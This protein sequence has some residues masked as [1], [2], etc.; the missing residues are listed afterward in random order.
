MASRGPR[1][2]TYLL[3]ALALGCT[4]RGDGSAAPGDQLGE[5]MAAPLTALLPAPPTSD[6]KD[7]DEPKWDVNN[8]Q[9]LDLE[10]IKLD[11]R[12]GTWLSLDISPDGKEI[13]F[14][15]LGDLYT[16]PIEG[17]EAT[18]LTEG[19]AWDMQPTYSPD[20]RSIA[21]TSDRGGGD[22]LWVVPRGGGEA[23]P[24]TKESFRLLNSP[25]WSPDGQYLVGRKHYTGT[26][27]L[28]AG[29]LW[30][31]HHS[32]G[33]GVQLTERANDQKDLGEP[34]FSPDGR[35]VYYSYDAT[36][37]R[38]FEYN[39]DPHAGIYEIERVDLVEQR[40]EHVVGGAGGA[41]RP[42]PSPDGRWLAYV[43]RVGL[44]T[45]LFV[46]D[47]ESGAQRQLFD[48]LDRDMQETWAIHGVYPR[49]DWTPDGGAIV[50]W[51]QG[52]LH[53]VDIA[54]G[55]VTAVPFHVAHSRKIGKA[56]RN[57]VE[58]HPENFD[59]KMLRGLTVAPDGQRVVYQA[60]GHLYVRE[61]PDG[62]ARRLTRDDDVFEHDPSISRDGRTV[63]Y[64]TW[65]DQGLGELRT[66]PLKGGRAKTISR[67]KGHYRE[68]VL[69]PDGDHV[70]FRRLG[71]GYL[72]SRLW[73][74]D[75]GIY[76][77]PLRKPKGDDKPL[78][79]SRSGSGIHFG[80]DGERVFFTTRS[81]GKDATTTL[82]SIGLDGREER[83]HATS[84]N[85]A[86]FRVSPD[87]KWLAFQ[88]RFHAYV[89]AFPPSN[90]PIRVGP[91][92][93]GIP[94][95]KVTQDAGT[96]LRWAGDSG[97]VHWLLG[98]ELFTR[99]LEDSFAFLRG[100]APETAEGDED[101]AET[102]KPVPSSGV[103]VGF[104][105]ASDIPEGRIALVG[106]KVVT[107]VGDQV[108]DDGV[109][110]IEGNRIVAVGE[111]GSV[112][113]PADA[114]S[115]D[116]SGHTVIPGL[117]DVHAHGPQGT[118]GIIPQQ[119]WLHYS[120]LAFGVT[121]VHDPS[122]DT[123]TIFASA[124]LA[125]AGLVTAPRIFSTG[126]ILYGAETPFM[127]VVN[128]LDD[129]RTHLRRMKA[130]GAISVKSY[131]QPRR[132]QRQQVLAAAKEIDM[133]VVPEGG[134][135]FQHNM[136][137]VVDGHTGVE[138]AIPVGAAYDDVEQLWG[139]TGVGYTPTLV[140]GYGGIWGEN[141]WYAES[142]VFNN[143]R[144][145]A[146][147][148]PFVYEGRSRRRMLASKGDWNHFAIAETCKQLL[149]AGVHIQLGAHGQREGLAAHWELW[150]LGQGGMTALEAI[151]AATLHG[152]AYVGLDRDLGSLEAGKLADI[153][154]VEGDLLADLR[155]SEHVKYTVLNGRVFEAKTMEQLAPVEIAPAPF[156]WHKGG[157]DGSAA[158][159]EAH[160]FHED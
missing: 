75:P 1:R 30:L 57:P 86:E 50:L 62:Q 66:V 88:E 40:I 42:T 21:F 139:Q 108:I 100:D 69:S 102:A 49:M 4:P 112:E 41:V 99:P 107:M 144:L 114:K 132:D 29:E 116:V 98:P 18:P 20:G 19:M 79:L 16:L 53:R 32:G 123:A 5:P 110:V 158:G 82:R 113:I 156:F 56:V 80:A 77:A 115:F 71:G 63:V 14:D 28:G 9:G 154:V 25:A 65:N 54:S 74:R 59:V 67:W 89:A 146:F 92:A 13:V 149:D 120:T 95:A 93:D 55:E 39:K 35:Y 37:G 134:S 121:T 119:N 124:E 127:A 137:F 142:D 152:A 122:N 133:M 61:L 90:R 135:L 143:R 81:G 52:G 160:T 131:N 159:G 111:R 48:G 118:G 7:E 36:P 38:Y 17:G 128:S 3:V 155:R 24:V 136:T 8:P 64:A 68:P 140:V 109:V 26:R 130:V 11:V 125:R 45:A 33:S 27:S 150:M 60:L 96:D 91:K 44:K 117:V 103:N 34:A 97:T 22:N 43:R 72:R 23:R 157:S 70:V 148:P 51:A 151:R 78:L 126:T 85:A 76:V 47:L 145:A 46:M 12:E 105:I 2:L 83:E 15:L 141:Y 106:G 6:A 101:D 58:V 153:A 104:S 87:G 147:V 138:H 10:E 73:T 94:V 31:Y 84:G 129:A